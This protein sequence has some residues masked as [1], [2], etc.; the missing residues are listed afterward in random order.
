M[1][2]WQWPVFPRQEECNEF[3]AT[4]VSDPAQPL[5]T[6]NWR[7]EDLGQGQG[8]SKFQIQGETY[9]DCFNWLSNWVEIYS[10]CP[11]L[12]AF[13]PP[14]SNQPAFPAHFPTDGNT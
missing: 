4:E 7:A 14:W 6:G 12:P 11:R 8:V 1:I 13:Y 9:N 2:E 5:P 10:N 3:C